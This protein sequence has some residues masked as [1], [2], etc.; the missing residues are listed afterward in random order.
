MVPSWAVSAQ[1]TGQKPIRLNVS[2]CCSHGAP[3][4]KEFKKALPNIGK[5]FTDIVN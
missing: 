1:P 2:E 5:S 3:S 4:P